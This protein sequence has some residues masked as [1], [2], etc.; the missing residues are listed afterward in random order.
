MREI[1]FRGIRK[2]NGEWVEGFYAVFGSHHVILAKDVWKSYPD[3]PIEL[4][5]YEVIPESVGQYIGHEDKNGHKIFEKCD[6]L[7]DPD[8][9]IS[10]VEYN[11]H[12]AGFCLVQDGV[13]LYP[14][15]D[16]FNWD[17]LELL[18]DKT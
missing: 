13:C 12:V 7:G 5:S 2:D 6:V 8:G 10:K 18:G 4:R 1:L 11:S 3:N 17:N 16:T 9:G 15:Q 14:G